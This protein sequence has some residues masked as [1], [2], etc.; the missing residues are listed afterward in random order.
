MFK[1]LEI[2]DE[3]EDSDDSSDNEFSK[4]QESLKDGVDFETFKS[5]ID[6]ANEKKLDE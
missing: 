2:K 6:K 3:P 5:N 1:W 4:M